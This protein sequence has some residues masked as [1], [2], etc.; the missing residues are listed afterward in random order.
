MT[1]VFW[2]GSLSFANGVKPTNTELQKLDSKG[3]K[4]LWLLN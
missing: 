4:W 2:N 3:K 1:D